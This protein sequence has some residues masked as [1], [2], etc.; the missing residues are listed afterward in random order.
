[1]L[2]RR[3]IRIKVLQALYAYFKAKSGNITSGRKE[4]LFSLDKIYELYI[5]LLTTFEEVVDVAVEKIEQAKAKRL[6]TETDLA[7]NTRFIASF[8]LNT[9]INNKALKVERERFKVNWGDQREMLGKIFAQIKSS[10]DYDQFM[11]KPEVSL[12]EEIEFIAK[13]FKDHIANWEPLQYYLDERSIYWSDDIDLVCSM[14]IKTIKQ[15]GKNSDENM[16]LMT[17]Y[18]DKEEEEA[19][20]ID[21]FNETIKLDEDSVELIEKKTQNWELDR[22]AQ[23]DMLIMKMAI[24]EVK[25]FTSIPTKV[26]L[27]EYIEISK[28]YSTPKS[29]TFI[30]GILDNIFQELKG[31]GKIKK[32]GRGLIE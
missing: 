22:I 7:P 15:I 6:P 23:M 28:F 12:E 32:V 27:N 14:V 3:H 5:I 18:K 8:V 11:N 9:L 20:A 26:T 4:L 24:A 31:E 21:L 25:T 10:D 13:M 30:N 2:N 29:N 1:M 19:F 17:L 16:P